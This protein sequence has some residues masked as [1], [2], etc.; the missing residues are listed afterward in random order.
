MA[1]MAEVREYTTL[2]ILSQSKSTLSGLVDSSLGLD[3]VG[4]RN[5][6]S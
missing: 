5:W 2:Y 4:G 3:H 1:R 6:R